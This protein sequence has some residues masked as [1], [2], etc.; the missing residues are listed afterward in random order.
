MLETVAVSGQVWCIRVTIVVSTGIAF[1]SRDARKEVA[2]NPGG[3]VEERA[4]TKGL[5]QTSYMGRVDMQDARPEGAER[6]RVLAG[7]F[8]AGLLISSIVYP[9]ARYAGSYFPAISLLA[10]VLAT[11]VVWRRHGRIA[12]V[13][14]LF[15]LLGVLSLS[16]T[17][18]IALTE[19]ALVAFVCTGLPALASGVLL[20]SRALGLTLCAGMFSSAMIISAT[21]GLYNINTYA[22]M[23]LLGCL[24][25][26]VVLSRYH[27]RLVRLL[28]PVLLIAYIPTM[29]TSDS[30]QAAVAWSVAILVWTVWGIRKMFWTNRPALASLLTALL[31]FGVLLLSTQNVI[32]GRS[33]ADSTS[34]TGRTLIWET[35]LS[36]C[37]SG[38]CIVGN[39]L[40]TIVAVSSSLGLGLSQAHN[41]FVLCLMELGVVGVG[42]IGLLLLSVVRPVLSLTSPAFP[43]VVL[44]A[45]VWVA[46][47]DLMNVADSFV[48]S[49]LLAIGSHIESGSERSRRVGPRGVRI[50]TRKW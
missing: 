9:I 8:G 25:A 45:I 20:K 4:P 39:G 18:D 17:R 21:T 26:C 2:P 46:S 33:I 48:L 14:S 43:A 41:I 15:L 29:L 12:R 49:L 37:E 30:A 31:L 32:W 44:A 22:K 47:S 10:A 36:S 11:P 23:I 40:G 27:R 16:W 24:S 35:L 28:I 13:W 42:V 38:S 6:P 34:D 3:V 7:L 50:S 5:S 19:S 1:S